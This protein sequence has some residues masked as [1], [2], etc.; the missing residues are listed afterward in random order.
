MKKSGTRIA[1]VSLV[2]LLIFSSFSN[3]V[4]AMTSPKAAADVSD[5]SFSAFGSNT[6]TDKNPPA[7]VN[8]DGS[9]TID[10]SGGKIAS[11]E[12][13]LS[14]YF[15]KLSAG[16]NFELHATVHADHYS[17][18]SQRAFGLMIRDQV[19]ENGDSSKH[20]SNY[21][22]VG[23]LDDAM[24]GFTS[25]GDLNKLAPFEDSPAPATDG[26]YELT[27]RK[28]GDTFVMTSNG[29]SETIELDQPFSDDIYAG[30]FVARNGT[31]TFSDVSLNVADKQVKSLQVDASQMKKEYLVDEPLDISGLEVTAVYEDNSEEKLTDDDYIVTGFDSSK[32][33]TNTIT[34]HYNG[35]EETVD[36]S[37]KELQ[38][39]GMEVKYYP[40]KTNYYL[41]DTFDPLGLVVTGN[42][43]DGYQTNELTKEQYSIFINGEEI[44]DSGYIFEQ[45]GKQTVTLQSKQNPDVKTTFSVQVKNEQLDSLEIKHA[46]TKQLY[47]LG[48]PLDLDGLIVEAHYT[49]GVSERVPKDQLKTSSFDSSTTGDKKVEMTYKDKQA[50]FTV[51]VKKKELQGLEV[52]EYPQTTYQKGESFNQDGLVV[53]KVYDNG[54]KEMLNE[55]E[56]EV[57]T[58]DYDASTMGVYPIQINPSSSTLS[59]IS[60]DVTVR[61]KQNYQWKTI[62]FGQSTDPETNYVEK[63]EDGSVHI[64]AEP[65]AGKITGDHDGITFYYTEIDADQDNFTLSADIQVNEY[66]KSPHHDGQESFGMMAR[67]AIGTEGNSNVFA[68][69]IAAVGGFSGGT[70][71]P[72]GTQF[73]IR[74]GVSSPD[75]AGSNGIEKVML[76]D[77]KPTTSNTYPAKNYHLTLSKTNSGF[78][79]QFNDGDQPMFFTPEL[80][81][82]QD[83]KVYVGFYTARLA[84]I[85]VSNMDFNV[86][87]EATDPPKVTPP[88]SP[89]EPEFDV[90]SRTKTSDSDYELLLKANADGVVKVKKGQEIIARDEPVKKGEIKSVPAQL[91]ENK[92][93]NFSVTFLPDDTQN[94]TSYT[95]QVKNVTVAMKT[96]ANGEA[97]HVSPSGQDSGDGTESSPLDL[98]TAVEFVQPGQKIIVKDGTYVRNGKLE[99]AK[100]NDGK[101]DAMK[102]LVAEKGARPVI[103]FD[104]QTE[105]VILSGDYWHVKG[106][107]FARTAGNT[108]GFVVGGSHNIVEQ[109]RFYENGD[110]G[111]QISRTDNSESIEDWPSDNFILNSESFDNRDPSDNNGDGF[112]AKLTAGTGNVFRGCISHNNIDDGWDLY[113][114]AGSGAIGPVLIEDSIAYENGKLTDGT[115]GDGD[116]NGFKLGGEGINVHHVIRNSIAFNN[117]AVGITSNSNPGII[118]ENNK[119]YNNAGGNLDFSTY[120]NIEEDFKIDGFVS[121]QKDYDAKDI[122]P[123]ELASNENFFFNGQ[124]SRNKSGRTLTE[125]DFVS[126]D[127]NLPFEREEQGEIL[128][129]DFLKVQFAPVR[130]AGKDRYET[131]IEV[132]KQGFKKADTVVIA[133]GD[134]FADALAGAPLAYKENAPILLSHTDYLNQ[135]VRKEI[136]RLGAKN[137]IMLGGPNAL[138]EFVKYQLQGLGLHVERVYGKTRYKTATNIA[139]RLD[140]NPEKA[141]VVNGSKFPDALAAAP[142]A[143]KQGYPILLAKQGSLPQ[144]TKWALEGINESI[145]VG[146]EG[147]VG[148][149]VYKQL[150]N[151]TR[152]SGTTRYKTAAVVMN[153]LEDDTSQTAFVSTGEEFADALTGA[154]LAAK[155]NA[156]MTLVKEDT[157]PKEVQQAYNRLPIKYLYILGGRNAVSDQA[158]DQL[159]K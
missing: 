156:A 152:Y 42:Y 12:E 69:N 14:Y 47:F 86:T 94:L 38:L 63:L 29:E 45:P 55:S 140:G 31:V 48:D 146:G 111:L 41:Q 51:H 104:K 11:S 151:P 103:D 143:A 128:T 149:D 1:V 144:S 82:V 76:N 112:A 16:D 57:S 135:K 66:A 84:D 54:D 22:A 32:P 18:D 129:G 24:R 121:Y 35:A 70:Q 33:G 116:K 114:K 107:D 17:P 95:K 68:S 74:S 83:D 145:V 88:E 115:V 37:I 13:G 89:V 3:S 28:S 58:A 97:I 141:I 113:T 150:P 119:S 43:E 127:P 36:L 73:F 158:V 78:S 75:G 39:T 56:Y 59:S 155:Q 60:F 53:S 98:D 5:W 122:Y 64:V 153:E 142:F 25:T 123:D 85:E 26:T 137:A 21:A 81:Q 67:D 77:E 124:V 102:S 52:S 100:Y 157:V 79:G 132:S 20:S 126:L 80:L 40:A 125:N 96:F 71:D 117:G 105:G 19:G 9:V 93:T 6:G 120:S 4:F 133:R 7:V 46:P 109:S 90:V 131:A 34:I 148:G 108:K 72:N 10:A 106:I 110:T 87:A 23:A 139:A 130:L 118:A 92:D 99:I 134:E 44:S 30:L 2:L 49:D 147:V 8:Q 136:S 101:K 159:Q 91:D 154:V 138:D 50:S 65:G 61:E 62:E 27:L 15:T